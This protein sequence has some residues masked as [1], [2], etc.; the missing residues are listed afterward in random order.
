MCGQGKDPLV[1]ACARVLCCVWVC[2]HGRWRWRLVG[3]LGGAGSAS[4][5]TMGAKACP[6]RLGG[7]ASREATSDAWR[8]AWARRGY[9]CVRVLRMR[10]AG[11]ITTLGRGGSDLS[12]TVLGAALELS[13]V[14]VWK[15]VDGE[16]LR[17]WCAVEEGRAG[18]GDPSAAQR[19]HSPNWRQGTARHRER[20][21]LAVQS[22]PAVCDL[23]R[24]DS[25]CAVI[26]ECSCFPAWLVALRRRADVGPAHRAQHAPRQR[27]HL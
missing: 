5:P 6:E 11:A 3:L 12:A 25:S 19:L 24:F 2:G 26:A 20:R 4:E 27:A 15:D 13:E 1:R 7:R 8:R 14:Q 10:C 22:A 21:R 16:R 17:V 23:G 9:A 18:K